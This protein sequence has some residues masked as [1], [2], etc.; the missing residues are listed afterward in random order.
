MMTSLCNMWLSVPLL[1]KFGNIPRILALLY[2]YD[3]RS[4]NSA[5]NKGGCAWYPHLHYKQ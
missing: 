4:T 2:N 3:Y 5:T 1:G